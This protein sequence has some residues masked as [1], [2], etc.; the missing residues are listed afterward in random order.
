M[1]DHGLLP[2]KAST[3]GHRRH[4]C[5]PELWL[6]RYVTEAPCSQLLYSN[7]KDIASGEVLDA[8]VCSFWACAVEWW[9]GKVADV[10][11]VQYVHA[12]R[13]ASMAS[14]NVCSSSRASGEQS[15]GG[16]RTKTSWRLIGDCEHHS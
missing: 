10:Q 13:Q 6:L 7:S 12:A 9:S 14:E 1:R 15:L 4:D 3:R 16:S 8:N 2:V 11:Y 5:P